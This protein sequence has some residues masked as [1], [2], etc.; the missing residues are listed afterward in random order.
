MAT[1]ANH[2]IAA[3][4]G[5]GQLNFSPDHHHHGPKPLRRL[6]HMIQPERRD[7]GLL[8]VFAIGIA[9]LSLAVPITVET[10]VNTVQGGN[11]LMMQA[12]IVLSFILL[13]CLV[14]AG[15]MRILSTYIVEL[16]QRRV[17]VRVVSELAYR[18]PRVQ[19]EAF[20][21]HHG[22]DLVNRFF[23][24]MTIQKS[25]STL[26][27]DGLTVVAQAIV[28]LVVLGFWH[29]FLLGFDTAVLLAMV[30]L[31]WLLGHGGIRTKI[32][33]SFAKYAVAGWLEEMVRHPVAFKMA[34]GQ[35]FAMVRADDLTRDYLRCRVN[36]FY[37]LFRQIIFGIIL[38]ALASAALLGL[39]GYLVVRNELTVGQLVAAE[40]IVIVL[41][42]SFVKLGKSLE[43]YY[44]LMAATDKLG[45]LVDLPIEEES[46][47]KVL[48]PSGPA[49]LRLN[50][51]RFSYL[52]GTEVLHGVDFAVEPGERIAVLGPS[53]C[54]KSTLMDM[55]LGLRRP[56]SGSIELDKF[57]LRD[58]NLRTLRSQ[59]ASSA[60]TEVFGGSILDNVRIG[61]EEVSLADIRTSLETVGMLEKLQAL[62]NGL[63]S[64]LLSGGNQLSQGEIQRL[65]LAR[66]LAGRPRLLLI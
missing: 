65:M 34:F 1:T 52:N 62:P 48:F 14:L 13:F 20:D 19:T 10:L 33:E 31:V 25:G 29:P 50:R 28:G 17:F 12:V 24:V 49:S 9:I 32:Q 60:G 59:L 43:S 37:I 3:A 39:G 40:L 27:L 53:G 66:A 44:D 42:G 58:I 7:I 8:S 51:V 35:D 26:L 38:Q 45:H 54:G 36:S 4:N 21:Q 63:N 11:L 2:E 64:P 15:A 41:V 47:E 5:H 46:G 57:D 61:R 18:L 55:L 56:S 6:L 22:P 23:D 30:F 16:I